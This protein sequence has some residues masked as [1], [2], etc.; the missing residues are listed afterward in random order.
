VKTIGEA[1]TDEERTLEAA[2]ANFG[3]RGRY[4]RAVPAVVSP[5]HRGVANACF[6]FDGEDGDSLFVKVPQADMA[7]LLD[8][9][10]A[11]E[12]ARIAG[13]A[14]VTP[15]LAAF[16]P[17]TGVAAF[18]WL[19]DGW[20]YARNDAL[21]RPE[22]L[23]AVLAHKRRLHDGPAFPRSDGPFERIDRL[24]GLLSPLAVHLPPDL[25]WLRDNLGLIRQAL[26]AA[27]WDSR[28]CHLDQPASNVM[29]GPGGA[30]L[31]VDFDSAGMADPWY[32]IGAFLTEA[33][34][35]DEDVRRGIA[36][37]AGTCSDG[38]FARARLWA[39]VDDLL[40]ALWA[41]WCF[42]TSPRR[43]IEFFKYASWR[44]MRARM[45]LLDWRFETWLRQL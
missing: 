19:D 10:A 40:W 28:P 14:G 43:D 5:V 31:L 7:P 39:I 15:P 25:P 16:D 12:A 42:A 8:P 9:A 2:L 44:F 21:A 30:V 4:L 35:F 45:T 1:A 17:E 20:D 32:D 6:R 13:E 41:T 29:L 23:E 27:G 18:G 37:Y 3:W 36:A 34:Q 11:A 33:F 38:L 22:V 26:T 24:E